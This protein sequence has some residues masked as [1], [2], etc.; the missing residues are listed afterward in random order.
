MKT[1]GILGMVLAMGLSGVPAPGQ[2]LPQALLAPIYPGAVENW[3]SN[4]SGLAQFLT[5]DSV[6]DVIR[7]YQRQ[8]GYPEPEL[9]GTPVSA[10]AFWIRP[11]LEELK[12]GIAYMKMGMDT[13]YAG[14]FVGTVE[15]CRTRTAI[16]SELDRLVSY[17]L[18]GSVSYGELPAAEM[19]RLR[20]RF[21][22]LGGASP[23][24]SQMEGREPVPQVVLV[25]RRHEPA[26]QRLHAQLR[27]AREARQEEIRV[28]QAARDKWET[29]EN[30]R[31][32]GMRD[33]E[34]RRMELMMQ[35]RIMEAMTLSQD[36]ADDMQRRRA[37]DHPVGP[38]VPRGPS[39]EQQRIAREIV[40]QWERAL[41]EMASLWYPVQISILHRQ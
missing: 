6:G 33:V 2:T 5:R 7:F 15:G 19:E 8:P 41:E 38:A 11:D 17:G 35:G 39:A 18:Q 27:Q 40:A 28:A 24:S 3:P 37:G 13:R 34:Q 26:V 30:E 25:Y 32:A 29:E 16:F 31:L 10:A 23:N 14:V 1:I 21:A 12:S 36:M 22:G 4:E 20:R 9:F